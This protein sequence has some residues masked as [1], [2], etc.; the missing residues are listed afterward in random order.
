MSDVS[1]EALALAAEN[2]ALHGL[3]ARIQ[4]V[5]GD[6]FEAVPGEH[7]D[8][9]LCNPPYVNAASMAALPPEFRA[10][11]AIALDGGLDG[12]DFVRRLLPQAADHLHEH[13]VLVIE[14][15]HEAGHF[16]RAFPGLQYDWLPVCE[17]ERMVVAIARPALVAREALVAHGSAT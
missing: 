12:M 17:G 11:P 14:I 8:L 4:L 7:F 3:Q 16:E 1:G 6:L 9:I 15:G 5:R 2:V 13:G 10:E